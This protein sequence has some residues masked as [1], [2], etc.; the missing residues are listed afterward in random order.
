MKVSLVNWSMAIKSLPAALRGVAI[1]MLLLCSHAICDAKVQDKAAAPVVDPQATEML[2]E[3]ARKEGLRL[4]RQLGSP[5]FDL[6]QKASR[7]LWEMGPP[8]L[9]VLQ[10]AAD[11]NFNN[12]AKVRAQ[13]L[14][15]FIKVGLSPDTDV[16]V[17]QCVTGFLDRELTV[18][19]RAVRKLC[20]LQKQEAARKLIALVSSEPDR[21]ALLES[22]SIASSDAEMALR[23]GDDD[24]FM[25]WIRD[26]ATV[27][28]QPLLFYYTLWI[29]GELEPEITRLKKEAKSELEAAE[30]FD[31]QQAKEKDKNPK[32]DDEA[33]APGQPNLK[34]LIGLL[35][36]LERWEEAL[37]LAEKVHDAES[38]RQLYHSILKE[39]G[40]WKG[41]AKLSIDSE[42]EQLDPEELEERFD[43]LVN[44]ASKYS[45]ALSHFYAGSEEGFQKS[46]AEI[47][48]EIAEREE[49]QGS[50]S[51]GDITHAR[52][53]RYTL[54]FDRSLKYAPL[55]KDVA[56][57][58][59]L[60]QHRRY[61]KL[62]EFFGF[63][64]FD[65]RA[66]YFKGRSRR[67]RSLVRQMEFQPDKRDQY[68]E[69][70][71]VEI[72][73]WR[74]VCSLFASL[75]LNEEAELYFRKLYFGYRDQVSH[76]GGSI[77]MDLQS[78]DALDSA[79]EIAKLEFERDENF[80]FGNIIDPQGYSHQAAGFLDGQLEEKISDPYL[81]CRRVA[82][83]VRSPTL[84]LDDDIDFWSEMAD[85]DFSNAS[86]AAW[87]LFS[88]WDL[89]EEDL[90]DV[91]SE[92]EEVERVDKLMK[93]GKY[94]QAARIYEAQALN[95]GNSIYYAKAWNAY[96]K[97]G[98]EAK[99]RRLR[100]LFVMS[101][102]PYDAYDYADGYT[103]T[104][105]QSL[106][107]D[108][109]RLHD[110]LE[111]DSVGSNC[112]YMW[113]MAKGDN[114][115][116]LSAHQKMVRTQILRYQYIDSPYLEDSEE[117]HS[118]LV[119]GALETGDLESAR[120]WF[121]KLAKFQPADSG[122][123]EDS[124]PVFEKVGGDEIVTEMF[125]RISADFY[126]ILKT[127]P[128]SAMYL[129][130]YAWSCACSG[131]NLDNGIELAKR[132]VE[133]RPSTAGY[134]DTLAELYHRDGQHDLAIETIREAVRINPM[135]DYYREQLEKYRSAKEKALTE[136]EPDDG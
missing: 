9:E 57:F 11:G 107:F 42:A 130:N 43:G 75:G 35:R 127:Y 10:T 82:Q 126:E 81:R 29:D 72:G 133:L 128:Q 89:E 100:L 120:R 30:K 23:L 66:K 2:D 115:G 51:Q 61:K 60:S 94:L 121:E 125:D 28:S 76:L 18:Q 52:F 19:T 32:G 26:P 8:A 98:D 63:N 135:R 103:G 55:K 12:E 90:I 80:E 47:E 27:N 20:A 1:V 136:S 113:R 15:S 114:N 54:D 91:S 83:L 64:S 34:T 129:N 97:A 44:S 62:F 102:D 7:E 78:M 85:V 24:R 36:F 45:I 134:I 38:R 39:S 25:E 68:E 108:A 73:N 101:F 31:A 112:Y 67:I 123:V 46:I 69:K 50:D 5:N 132:A 16:E 86:H 56:T 92:G 124:F 77:V 117:D 99:T 131:R 109:Y 37:E 13:D 79:W 21:N 53:L 33:E 104:E 88:I 49:K 110:V 48:A 6:R 122:F 17:V 119:E 118:R 71:N 87:Q 41:F 4:V 105:W 22:C 14:I 3:Q 84:P 59:L 74:S 106:P 58:Q 95:D 93:E 70:L 116:V 111:N 40:N 96:S 65:S